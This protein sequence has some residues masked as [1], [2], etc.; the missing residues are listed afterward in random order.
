ME[1]AE[2]P[3]Y[4][5]PAAALAFLALI[6]LLDALR[7]AL[8]PN[9]RRILWLGFAV[10]VVVVV[11][12]DVGKLTRSAES[13]AERANAIRADMRALQVLR[14]VLEGT[15]GSRVTI[16]RLFFGGLTPGGYYAV[17]DALSSPVPGATVESLAALQPQE[18][19]RVDRLIQ[20]LMHD[21]LVPR[22]SALGPPA[23]NES[24]GARL[25]GLYDMQVREAGSGGCASLSVT[26]DDPFLSFRGVRGE[27]VWIRTDGQRVL[28]VFARIVGDVFEAPASSIYPIRQAWY[29]LDPEALPAGLDWTVRVDPPPGSSAF[30]LCLAPQGVS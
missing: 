25:R 6:P 20:R 29:R 13:Y 16:D 30:D 28:Q 3:R 10:W 7:R 15:P 18:R 5:Y 12:G 27:S 14:P 8:N 21:G 4:L 17:I 11:S 19:L 26:G 9:A 22:F 24:I 2:A 1:G 23:M